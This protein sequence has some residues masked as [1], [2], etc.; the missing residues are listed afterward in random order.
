MG[1][2][3]AAL[4][5]VAAL[6]CSCASS[7]APSATPSSASACGTGAPEGD[8]YQPDR[9]QVLDPCKHAVGVVVDVAAED[10]GDYHVWFKPDT[11]FEY[12]MN[13]ENHFQAKP[14]MLAEI[15]PDCTGQPADAG[16]AAK[17]PKSKLPLPKLGDHIAMD[18][19]WVLDTNHGWR[20]IHPVDRIEILAHA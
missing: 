11:G 17:C 16:A 4:I 1:P 9:L 3:R 5:V 20:E 14:A 12:L 19:P 10:D 18:G 7:A 2:A 8:V 6:L 15:T 13:P